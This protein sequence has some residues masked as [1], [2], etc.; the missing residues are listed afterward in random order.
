[1]LK[2][3]D[4]VSSYDFTRFGALGIGSGGFGPLYNIGFLYIFRL[5]TNALETDQQFVRAGISTLCDEFVSLFEQAGG[6]Y[7]D[8]LHVDEVK[9]DER[10]G[11]PYVTFGSDKKHFDA[12]I[13]AT[14]T[15]AMEMGLRLSQYPPVGQ[16]PNATV[17]TAPIAEAI[18]R[19]HVISSTKLFLRTRKFWRIPGN[20][21]GYKYPRNLLSDTKVPQVYTLEYD[22]NTD[23][24][25]SGVVL[26]TYTWEDDA[27]KTQA[28]SAVDRYHLFVETV[29]EITADSPFPDYADQLKPFTGNLDQDLQSID[30]QS[31]DNQF[32]AFTLARP[33]QDPFVNTMFKDFTRASNGVTNTGKIFIAGDCVSWTGGWAE[34]ALQTGL[35]AASAV[36]NVLG[37]EQK[38]AKNPSNA[39]AQP[40]YNYFPL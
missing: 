8:S 26:L 13:V 11:R 29:R 20:I 12:V 7:Y 2:T 5:L 6:I 19:T 40:F 36:I 30:W 10:Q 38:I 17:V 23:P 3:R 35:N 1:M 32:G 27:V 28:L 34:G 21:Q 4:G 22:D 37:G 39:L 9:Y 18:G 14:N 24:S 25:S 31:T 15:R 33:G 16:A